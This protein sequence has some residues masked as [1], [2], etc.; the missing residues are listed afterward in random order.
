M[1]MSLHDYMYRLYVDSGLSYRE[2]SDL[3]GV[4]ANTVQNYI[5][6]ITKNHSIDK[7]RRIISA[8]GGDL[9]VLNKLDLSDEETAAEEQAKIPTDASALLV[10]TL[11]EEARTSYKAA[12]LRERRSIKYL[13]LALIAESIML[14][15]LIAAVVALFVYDFT[16][17]DRGWYQDPEPEI[18]YVTPDPSAISDQK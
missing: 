7:A 16:H 5:N 9:S 8:L 11:S 18:I 15:V 17:P 2:I 12:V 14:F 13:S 1:S 4:A 10:Y 3:S 6:G